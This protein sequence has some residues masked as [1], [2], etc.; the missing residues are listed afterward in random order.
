MR[1]GKGEEVMGTKSAVVILSVLA[2]IGVGCSDDSEESATTTTTAAGVTGPQRYTVVV[3]GPSTLGAENLVYG[4]FFPQ[5]ISARPGDTI[6]FDNRSSNDIH[7]VTFGV[8]SDRSDQPP[9]VL[10]TGQANP[11]A[12]A[13]CFT[14]EPARPQLTC[15]APPASPPEMTGT[16]YWNSGIIYPTALPPEAGPKQTTVKLAAGIAPGSHAI[17]C[18]LHP[19]MEGTLRVVGSDGDR[20]TPAQVALAADK[21]LGE[22][23]AQAAALTVPTPAPVANGVEVLSGWGDK[24]V[25]V[26]RFEPE[27][28]SVKVGQTVSWLSASPYMP[29]TVSFQPPFQTPAQPNALLPTGTK[30]GGRFAGGVSHSG[31]IGPPAEAPSDRFSLVFTKAGTYPYLCILHPGMAG[32]VQVS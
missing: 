22:A 18:V 9:V 17:T 29:H 10:K 16:G 5:T 6:V 14:T 13:P 11:V 32:T 15:P 3:D 7:T 21:E 26:N 12:F 28:A 8:K 2:L 25:A 24:L 4:T 30:S 23:K 19:F 20:L 27:T 1:R 31:A